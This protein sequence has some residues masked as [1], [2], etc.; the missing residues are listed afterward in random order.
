VIT[1]LLIANRGEIAV[2][3]IKTCRKLGIK[4]VAVYS[5]ADA[6]ALHVKLADEAFHI[7]RSPPPFSYLNVEKICEVVKKSGADAVHPGYGFLAENATFAEAIE[8]VGVIWVGPPAKVMKKIESKSFSRVIASEAGVPVIPGSLEP[9]DVKKAEEYLERFG[10]ILIKADLGGGGKGMKIVRSKDELNSFCESAQREANIAFGRPYVYVEKQLEKPRHIEVQILADKYGNIVSLGERECSIQRRYQKIIEESPSPVVD[11]K[12]R[13]YVSELAR[14]VME[15]CEYENAGTVEFLRDQDGNFYFLEINKRIQVEHPVTECV[16]GIDLIEQQL[17]IA[18]GEPLGLHSVTK[19]RGHSMECRIYAEDPVTFLP[20]PGKILKVKLPEGEGIRVDHAL[21]DGTYI[22]P[23]YDP[24]IAKVVVHTEDR[25]AS[26][27]LMR[28]ALQDFEV[29]G[30]K[31]SIPFLLHIV[32]TDDFQKG[33]VHTQ[34]VDQ[35][36]VKA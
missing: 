33:D 6:N 30:I 14:K 15:K 21:E 31:T 34:F 16:T 35:L 9:V 8:K 20:S 5:D 7:G 24:L 4:T 12:T 29:Q 11:E 26:I 22:P 36:F 3:I 19:L 27:R 23:F 10:C 28:K 32:G 18:S 13:E 17:R 1:K 2:R 25:E